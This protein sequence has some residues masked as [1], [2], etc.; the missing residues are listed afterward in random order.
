[1][2]KKFTELG[3][4]DEALRAVTDL[5]YEAP[6]PVQEQAIPAILEGRDVIAAAK[7]GT[8]KTAA[9]CLPTISTLPHKRQ[10]AGPT[11]LILTPTRELAMQIEEVART[12]AKQAHKRVVCLLGGV[13]YEP[14][15]KALAR[16]CDVLV[17][18]PGRLIDLLNQKALTLDEAGVLVLDEAD[19][20]LDMGFLPDVRRIVE[21]CPENDARQTL[22]F[23]ATIDKNIEKNLM[24]LLTD[25][26]YVEIAH[27][28]ETADLVDEFQVQVA[29][30]AKPELLLAVLEKFGSQR[31]IVFARTKY[32][33]DT[34]VRKLR[35]QGYSVAPIHGGRSQAQRKNALDNFAAGKVDILVA[36]DILARGIDINEVPYIVNFD[37]PHLPEDYVHRIGRT[38]RAGEE[39]LAISF[40]TPENK[41][42]M[43]EIK[44]LIGHDIP[45][46]TIEGFDAA[47]SERQMAEKAT[48][49][50]ARNDAE[51]DAVMR[52]MKKA[53]K[54]ELHGEEDG[55][56]A[57]RRGKGKKKPAS[58]KTAEPP[59][60]KKGATGK[61]KQRAAEWDGEE[62][63]KPRHKGKRHQNLTGRPKSYVG[64]AKQD[65]A[66]AV[67]T[68]P[69]HET[70]DEQR[71]GGSHPQGSRT[72]N[73]GHRGQGRPGARRTRQAHG[74]EGH[75]ARNGQKHGQRAG[76][77]HA[78]AHTGTRASAQR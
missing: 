77:G 40:V 78:K 51:I 71:A 41:Q 17:A 45:F 47:A 68:H 33:V 28:G 76:K 74:H 55:K 60:K 9:F 1:M 34:C 44:K 7:T 23:S 72:P 59:M 12:I 39:G 15:R 37:L 43:R 25:P 58:A 22:L 67:G 3:L 65:G 35:A 5:G 75:T 31:V 61:K 14:Q 2:T 11:M 73:R 70:D 69:S 57:G 36:T 50:A 66:D 29:H 13:S 18:T 56:P 42:E 6:T 27:K 20:M 30:R 48:R 32:R 46:L 21:R 52:E 4:P 16:G 54:K 63:V 26:V 10:G 53:R 64:R 19:R 8:G 62:A 38:G 49:R 24:H